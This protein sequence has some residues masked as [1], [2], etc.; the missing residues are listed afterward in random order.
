[1]ISGNFKSMQEIHGL[2]NEIIEPRKSLKFIK[3][4]LEEKVYSVEKRMDKLD[5]DI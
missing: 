4:N 2:K 5:S 3:N 1:M